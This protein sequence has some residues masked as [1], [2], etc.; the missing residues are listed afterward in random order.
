MTNCYKI[1]AILLEPPIRF[2]IQ[3]QDLNTFEYN[4]FPRFKRN[5]SNPTKKKQKPTIKKNNHLHTYSNTH[6][7][8]TFCFPFIKE[9]NKKTFASTIYL[10]WGGVFFR[11]FFS[12]KKTHGCLYQV[13]HLRLG[14]LRLRITQRWWRNGSPR[15]AWRGWRSGDHPTGHGTGRAAESRGAQKT[16][17]DLFG[18]VFI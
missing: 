13:G 7:K 11:F 14:P 10:C 4:H 3:T 17:M 6:H 12:L 1:F 18:G 2:P 5:V 8:Y 15:P 16:G 9:K